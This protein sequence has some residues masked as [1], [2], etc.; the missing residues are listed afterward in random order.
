[1]PPCHI[2]S[3][4]KDFYHAASETKHQIFGY[5]HSHQTK[6]PPPQPL[7]TTTTTHHHHH[8]RHHH[9]HHHGQPLRGL[10]F[11]ALGFWLCTSGGATTCWMKPQQRQRGKRR[12]SGNDGRNRL[13]SHGDYQNEKVQFR[14]FRGISKVPVPPPKKK[15]QQRS[16]QK[17]FRHTWSPFSFVTISCF[18][19]IQPQ[20]DAKEHQPSE[21]NLSS[22]PTKPKMESWKSGICATPFLGKKKPTSSKWLANFGLFW[23]FR[24]G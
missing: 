3:C 12:S 9:H 21:F 24:A 5:S 8:P 11:Q 16:G 7:T 22:H 19:Y 23:W 1:M 17:T 18:S 20:S 2:S 13:P 4:I 6:I 15:L 10:L 14:K